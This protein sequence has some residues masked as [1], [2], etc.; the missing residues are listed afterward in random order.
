VKIN[1][2][3]HP[4]LSAQAQALSSEVLDAH[5]ELARGLL[6][7]DGARFSKEAYPLARTAVALQVNHQVRKELEPAVYMEKTWSR[8]QRGKTYRDEILAVLDP[9]A[10]DLA[11]LALGGQAYGQPLRSRR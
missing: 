1:I 8:G 6:R 11:N 2:D 10:M 4:L 3:G 7:L 9:S 5:A